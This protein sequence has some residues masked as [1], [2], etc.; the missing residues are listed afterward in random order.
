MKKSKKK[1]ASTM[2]ERAQLI[3]GESSARGYWV[4]MLGIFGLYNFCSG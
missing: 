2:D 1:V 4:A 3:S